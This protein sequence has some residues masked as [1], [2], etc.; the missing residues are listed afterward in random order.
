[1]LTKDEE[2]RGKCII[3]I[4]IGILMIAIGLQTV[5][6]FENNEYDLE[7]EYVNTKDIAMVDVSKKEEIVDNSLTSLLITNLNITNQD[8]NIVEVSL[9]NLEVE[10][11]KMPTINSIEVAKETPKVIWRLP[12]EM[13]NISQYPHYGHA[14]YDIT[15]PRGSNEPIFPVANGTITNIYRDPAGALV[16]TILHDIDG[17][18]YTSQYAHL[19][20]FAKDIYIGK[21]VTVNDSIG[22]MGTTG[23]STGVHLHLALVDCALYDPNDNNCRDLNGFFR[24]ANTRVSQG[25]YGLGWHMYVPQSWNSR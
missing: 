19:S 16:V 12:T 18:R 24:Y 17:K 11:T 9:D 15:S 8:D 13:G 20:S 6:A 25:Y 10:E 5:H 1:M 23:Y 3:T 2:T 22:R 7:Y 14:A 21:P 4:A